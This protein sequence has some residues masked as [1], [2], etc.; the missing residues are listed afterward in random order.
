[1]KIWA[2]HTY[3]YVTI[4]PDHVDMSDD[5]INLNKLLIYCFYYDG[6]IF[7]ITYENLNRIDFRGRII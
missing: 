4:R 1:M 5:Y 6:V 3:D 2:Q 7:N